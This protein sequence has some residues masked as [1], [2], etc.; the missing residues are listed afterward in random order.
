MDIFQQLAEQIKPKQN[1]VANADQ[2]IHAIMADL[3]EQSKIDTK[4]N[5]AIL[6]EILDRLEFCHSLIHNNYNF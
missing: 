4:E 6:S 5:K 1:P 3:E 2:S